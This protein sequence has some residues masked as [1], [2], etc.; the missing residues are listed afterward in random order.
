MS[1]CVMIAVTTNYIPLA[2]MWYHSFKA[3]SGLVCDVVCFADSQDT[4]D[5]LKLRIPELDIRVLTQPTD[6]NYTGW[7][8]TYFYGMRMKVFGLYALQGEYS[9][10][11]Y[12]DV[13]T[14]ILKELSYLST[15]DLGTNILAGVPDCPQHRHPSLEPDSLMMGELEFRAN[16]SGSMDKYVNAGMLVVDLDKLP[17]NTFMEYVTTEKPYCSDQDYLNEVCAGN[18]LILPD[19]YNYLVDYWLN[20][21]SLEL[22]KQTYVDM[23]NAHVQ[24]FH[25]AF[26]PWSTTY[27]AWCW[28]IKLQC[29]TSYYDQ[30]L[31]ECRDT[32]GGEA[33]SYLKYADSESIVRRGMREFHSANLDKVYLVQAGF[34]TATPCGCSEWAHYLAQLHSCK[35]ITSNPIFNWEGSSGFVIDGDSSTPQALY[36]I[37]NK[38]IIADSRED[39]TQYEMCEVYP[40]NPLKYTSVGAKLKA[41]E[42]QLLTAL[43]S[44][45]PVDHP[46]RV[47]R[48]AIR[49]SHPT[50]INHD[51]RGK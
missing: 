42:S 50:F 38:V 1:T 11:I 22:T 4:H 44:L 23:G 49:S 8:D 47:Y 34:A 27:N 43:E 15:L 2:Q 5:I 37:A 19:T 20:N 46:I 3:N 24:H 48:D 40:K 51:L 9:K 26:K 17:P 30:V 12:F 10:C 25:G 28:W 14:L 18:V 13:D 41:S 35:L 31:E 21:P 32:F 6:T 39:V 36:A 7:D 29:S 16:I 33:D 45:L